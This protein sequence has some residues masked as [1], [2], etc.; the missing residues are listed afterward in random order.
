MTIKVHGFNSGSDNY[1]HVCKSAILKRK[2][3]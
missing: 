3:E 2:A 1:A